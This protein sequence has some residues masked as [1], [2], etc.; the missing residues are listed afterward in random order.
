MLHSLGRLTIIRKSLIWPNPENRRPFSVPHSTR[1]VAATEW[2]CQFACSEVERLAGNS[3]PCLLVS[4]VVIM[5]LCF[6]GHSQTRSVGQ[7]LFGDNQIFLRLQ[8]E[9]Q[10]NNGRYVLESSPNCQGIWEV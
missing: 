2:P 4:V 5:M 3:Y 1:I 6:R 9:W 8:A 7:K 10:N